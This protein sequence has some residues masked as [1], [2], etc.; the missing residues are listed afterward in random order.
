MLPDVQVLIDEASEQLETVRALYDDSLQKKKVP[1]RLKVTIKNLLENQRS[2]LEYLARQI[3]EKHGN[4]GSAYVYWPVAPTATKFDAT[5]DQKM[6]GVRK[7]KKGIA[8]A[9]GKYQRYQPGCEWLGHLVTLTNEN[10]HQR[11]TAQT[12][13]ETRRRSVGGGAVSWDPSAV[14][15]GSGVW[16][17]GEPVNPVTQRTASTVE[18]IYV[19]WLF[20][21]LGVSALRTLEEIQTKLVPAVHDVSSVAGL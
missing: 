16:L 18:T 20:D 8:T 11:L 12:R 7:A 17:A 15:F 9:V 19:D 4:K 5:M 10:K 2:A 14:T 13:T 1:P 6:P 3:T 21:D